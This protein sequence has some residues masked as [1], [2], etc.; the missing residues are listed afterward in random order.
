MLSDSKASYLIEGE[1][2]TMD[3]A[4]RW[5]NILGLAGQNKL[6]LEELERLQKILIEDTRFIKLGLREEGGFVGSHGRNSREPIPELISAKWQDLPELMD[7]LVK[8]ENKM[9]A[10]GYNAVLTAAS[11]SFGFVFIHPF[12]DGNGRIHRYLINDILTRGKF[13]EAGIIFPVSYVILER[14][15]E[16]REVLKS[17]SSPRLELIEWKPT[18]GMNIDVINESID[19]Y[20]YFDATK[21]AEFLFSCIEET[22]GKILPEEIDYLENYD[23]MKNYI[24]KNFEMDD[25]NIDLLIN[26]L[27]QN[28]GSLSQRAKSKEFKLLTNSEVQNLENKYCEIFERG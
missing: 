28:G 1:Q 6:T 22:T 24:N 7:G 17:Y 15:N 5:A 4:Q 23:K 9:Q 19:L 20:R 8:A 14:I 2:P 10:D 27:K 3:R 18:E 26:F 21:Q 16:Y 25:S 11:I 12:V 13:T